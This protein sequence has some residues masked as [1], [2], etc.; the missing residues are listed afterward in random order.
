MGNQQITKECNETI[1]QPESIRVLQEIPLSN[2]IIE[3]NTFLKVLLN[4]EGDAVDVILK[5]NMTSR[6]L[7]QEV[8]E[9]SKQFCGKKIIALESI[10]NSLTV[11]DYWLQEFDNNISD[12]LK[13]RNDILLRAVY[14]GD[15]EEGF[16]Y[17]QLTHF[18]IVKN[19][20]K[21]GTSNV[22]LGK[23]YYINY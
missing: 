23:K 2:P 1:H 13:G 4:P 14:K 16:E 21:G 19:I 10:D 5:E 15:I 3:K 9:K 11:L 20:G 18:Y 7:L 17:V 12:V 6:Q 22:F 8:Q